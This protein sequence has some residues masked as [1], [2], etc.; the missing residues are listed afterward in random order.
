MSGL[1]YFKKANRVINV[2]C[3]VAQL[4]LHN[5]GTSDLCIRTVEIS[6]SRAQKNDEIKKDVAL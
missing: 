3:K 4:S 5:W 1:F 6:L 2:R